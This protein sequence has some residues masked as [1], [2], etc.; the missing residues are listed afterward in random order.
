MLSIVLSISTSGQISAEDV[1]KHVYF[2]ASDY[3]EGRL[4]GSHGNQIARDYIEFYLKKLGYDVIEQK[5][6]IPGKIHVEEFTVEP[7]LPLKPLYFSSSGDIRGRVGRDIQ[8]IDADSLSE[9]DM[10]MKAID[11]RE[12]GKKAVIFLVSSPILQ[13]SYFRNDLKIVALQ[14]EKKDENLLGDGQEVHIR[15]K[16]K[17]ENITGINLIA[18]KKG[19]P[20]SR[21]IMVGAHYD[22]LGYGPM[23]SM[24]PDLM[25]IH[26]GADDNASGVAGVLEL[27]EYFADRSTNHGL[28][29]VFWDA[30]ELGL[31]GSKY[32][33][34]HPVIPL[35]S[36]LAYLNFDMI[37]RMKDS[38]LYLIGIKTAREFQGIVDSLKG[39]YA[40]K[41]KSS[42]SGFGASDQNAFYSSRVPVLH[43]FTGAHSD[44]HT[45]LDDPE[46]LNYM[47][48]ETVLKF[49]RDLILT[50]DG[51]GSLRYIKLEMPSGPSRTRLKVSLGVI[52]DYA[53]SG[54]EG[55][56]I[57]GTRKD[58]PA[59]RAGLREGDVII[60]IGNY[61]IK[62]I[63]D[64]MYALS[65]YNPG[66]EAEIVY[67]RDG[68]EIRS[69]VKFEKARR[70]R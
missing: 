20:G 12:N 70:M 22:H 57:F 56:R 41:I 32:Y 46:K 16:V 44:Y 59:Y 68:R 40:L 17:K 24:K 10:M 65:R 1:R 54:G 66:D 25:D 39:L 2:L 61:R 69:R 27:A 35:D 58:S 53:S 51:F 42:D 26:N 23:G 6:P 3:T 19:H 36:I 28:V 18:I 43:F 50:L 52:P 34:E 7:N 37:G 60:K 9:F 45:P 13:R 67:L 14:M 63:Y 33:I 30:E 15:L 5:F 21:Y 55:L 48:E 29:F 11:A 47:G 31:L 38:T 62:N 64:L 4:S 49:A 8:V